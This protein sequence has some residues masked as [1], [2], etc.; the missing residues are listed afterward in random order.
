MEG[1]RKERSFQGR[2]EGRK[3]RRNKQA[4]SLTG[5]LLMLKFLISFCQ[6]FQNDSEFIKHTQY[7]KVL[8]S[9]D[10]TNLI[11]LLVY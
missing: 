10:P 11:T 6:P 3:G 9:P 5:S 2:E 4:N 1:Q 7:V 8:G